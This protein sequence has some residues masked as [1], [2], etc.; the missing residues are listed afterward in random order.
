MASDRKQR[1]GYRTDTGKKRAH[2]EDAL[3]LLP[4]H[5]LFAVAD[6]V[7]GQKSGEIASRKAMIGIETWFKNHLPAEGENLSGKDRIQ[8]VRSYFTDCLRLVNN[9]ILLLA[10]TDPAC[11]NMATTAVIAYFDK[12]VLFLVN[13]GDSRAY[14]LRGGSIKQLTEDH[15]YV[16]EMV[17]AGTLTQD[18]ARTHPKKNI[19]TKALGTIAETEPDFFPV[20]VMKSDRVLLCTDGLHGELPDTEIVRILMTESDPG[21]CAETLVAAANE[22]GGR[23]NITVIVIDQKD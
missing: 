15:T 8:Q 23:D 7:G 5:G 4:E 16:N 9:D 14:L 12:D 13:I 20:P 10:S 22:K 11:A 2:N 18:E 21:A 3:L 19:I 17:R 6:G 1:F